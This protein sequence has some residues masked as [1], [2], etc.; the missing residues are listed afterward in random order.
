MAERPLV[1]AK[2]LGVVAST[3]KRTRDAWEADEATAPE[4][5]T[6]GGMLRDA[7]AL[8]GPVSVKVGQTLSQRPD[9]VGE[10]ACEALKALQTRNAAFSNEAAFAYMADEFGLEHPGLLAPGIVADPSAPFRKTDAHWLA[11][12]EREPAAVVAS[13]RSTGAT[14]GAR[15][16]RSSGGPGSAARR[17]T[18]ATSGEVV[19]TVAD[20]IFDELNYDLE[21]VNAAEFKQSLDF[22]GFVDV[23]TFLPELSTSRV[24]TTEWIKGDHM[25]RLGRRDG[26]LMTQLAVEACTASLVLTGFVHADPHEGN[27]MLQDDG[28]VVFLDFGLMSRVDGDIMESFATGIRACL[29]EDYATL[30]FVFQKVGFL[31]TPLEFREAPG[32]PYRDVADA[33]GLAQFEDELRSAMAATEGGS[34]RFGALAEV[35]NGKLSKRWKMFTPPYCLLLIRTFLTLEGIAAQVDPDFNIYEMSLPWALRRSLAPTSPQG[36]ATLRGSLLGDDNRVKWDA[37]LDLVQDDGGGSSEAASDVQPEAD[38]GEALT[39]VVGSSGGAALRKTMRDIDAADLATKLVGPSGRVIRRKAAL[40]LCGAIDRKLM[41]AHREPAPQNP[42]G[43]VSLSAKGGA[44]ISRA[45]KMFVAWM[46]C[47]RPKVAG[48][49]TAHVAKATFSAASSA[50]NADADERRRAG[51]VDL[52]APCAAPAGPVQPPRVDD[53]LASVARARRR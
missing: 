31:T 12:L 19:D 47:A 5:R 30:A 48:D 37:I 26:A 53:A 16:P 33:E 23:P 50:R 42:D 6:R 9:L 4:R 44:Q 35:L 15:T 8:L 14:H 2:R 13:G 20:G 3:F 22:L 45:T 17:S 24:L 34:S 43:P 25:E 49:V 28:K 1:V 40:E 51:V 36:V 11:S 7:I 39:A 21:A 32:V 52:E 29:A 46:L 41:P 10:E 38:L 18:T 27:L